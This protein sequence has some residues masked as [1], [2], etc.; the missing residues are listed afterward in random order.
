MHHPLAW[1][2]GLATALGIALS[3]LVL[4]A[5]GSIRAD[6]T[7]EIV[8][9][10]DEPVDG[11]P[12][13]SRVEIRGVIVGRVV[14]IGLAEDHRHVEVRAALGLLQL[15]RLGLRRPGEP[16]RRGVAPFAQLPGLRAY[17]APIGITSAQVL[18]LDVLDPARYP[19]PELPFDVPW[20][21]VPATA[22]TARTI[23]LSVD[24]IV[25]RIP[26]VLDGADQ[27]VAAVESALVA[28]DP[29]GLKRSFEE[30][31]TTGE[32][33]VG[34]LE[35]DSVAR[36]DS[37]LTGWTAELAGMTRAVE[38][39]QATLDD[40][41]ADPAKLEAAITDMEAKVRSIDLPEITRQIRALS[42]GAQSALRAASETIEAVRSGARS[43]GEL[44]RWL[45]GVTGPM[46]RDP[47]G[48]FFGEHRD[49]PP[50][51]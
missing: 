41:A 14:S 33:L 36:I 34:A 26:G 22:S 30:K 2:V 45:R 28:I 40:P 47:G 48:L 15:E 25:P 3:W 46:D 16:V 50:G 43:V 4:V 12:L 8:T 9:Y 42:D 10:L 23:V 39:L 1:K 17:L 49:D 38:Q 7:L 24:A 6:E 27:F 11:L 37:T 13:D 35:P 29:P 51:R 32:R 20:N 21:Y 44:S 31:L 5:W 18:Q 19:P